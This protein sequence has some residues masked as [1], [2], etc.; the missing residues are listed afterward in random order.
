MNRQPL[1][2]LFAALIIGILLRDNVSVT[3]GIVA[4]VLCCAVAV[5]LLGF[6]RRRYAGL[7]L[8]VFFISIGFALQHLQVFSFREP[9]ISGRHRIQFVMEKK[10][11]SN[12]KNRRYIARI[13]AVESSAIKLPVNTV[14]SIPKDIAPLDFEHVYAA[15][16][17]VNPVTERKNDYQ[18][19]YKKYLSRRNVALQS[20]IPGELQSLPRETTL[21]EKIKQLRLETLQKIDNTSL[22]KNSREFIKGIILADRTEM[23]AEVTRDFT[24]SGLVHLLAIS[25][26][27][28]AVIFGFVMLVLKL[29]FGYRC[30]KPAIL[31]SLLFIWCFAIFID[32]G[33]S[34]MRSCLM[35][36]AYYAAVLLNRKPDLL[37]A[38]SLAGLIILFVNPQQ[39]FDVGFQLSFLAVFGIYWL[40]QPLTDLLP[41]FRGKAARLL[42]GVFTVTMSAQIITLPLVLYYF[43][44]FSLISFVANLVVIPA[45]EL[46]IV[47]SLLMTFVI[48]I[49]GNVDVLNVLYDQTIT[50]TLKLIHF[51][52][53]V[54][55]VFF[56]NISMSMVEVL[57][58]FSAIAF[59]RPLLKRK[60]LRSA[61][62][63][64]AVMC[65]FTITRLS[66]DYFSSTQEEFR[67]HKFYKEQ[68]VSVRQH[69]KVDFYGD[70]TKLTPKVYGFVIQPYVT[71]RR[72]G[73][74]RIIHQPISE[75]ATIRLRGT[76]KLPVTED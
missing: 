52:A 44:Q 73:A 18:F 58:L 67:I 64:V 24:R 71:K 59:L 74:Y 39:L 66:L 31:L 35:I 29:L 10:L 45:A 17:F 12:E 16:A 60:R 21:A 42:V 65:L 75:G 23:D 37:H 69:G 55:S 72:A 57:L 2:V 5:L 38:L 3:D 15:E 33:S 6:Q 40:N 8:A 46:L 56:D 36:T 53:D 54:D 76:G 47:F 62:G 14:I 49:L 32:Y 41:K 30:R 25:G 43:H 28:M 7:S 9:E 51:F 1:L 48:A 50:H 11:N 70:T 13:V 61:I 68:W 20:Y 4:I 22:R 19:D 63:F 34:V 27:H 26:T